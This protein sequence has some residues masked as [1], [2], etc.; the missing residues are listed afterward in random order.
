MKEG[1]LIDALKD[2]IKR[3]LPWCSNGKESTCQCRGHRFNPRSRKIPHA[4]GQLSPCA[5]T[6]EARA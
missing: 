2:H 4:L 6:T 3:G 5:T 1:K